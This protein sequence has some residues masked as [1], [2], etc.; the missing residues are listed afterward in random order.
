MGL[1]VNL[2]ILETF[3]SVFLEC[4]AEQAFMSYLCSAPHVATVVSGVS[5]GPALTSY[6]AQVMEYIG[7]G[8][9][10]C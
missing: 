2:I 8:S 6:M 5:V 3:R 4:C 10:S 9:A 7:L 1:I